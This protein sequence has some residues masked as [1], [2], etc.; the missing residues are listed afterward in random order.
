MTVPY[1]SA[2]TE[3]ADH[4]YI[5]QNYSGNRQELLGMIEQSEERVKAFIDGYRKVDVHTSGHADSGAIKM[6]MEMTTP[7]I[8]IPIHTEVPTAFDRIYNKAKLVLLQD[9]EEFT[10]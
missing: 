1:R 9:G 10:M 2:F 3:I 6:L 8:I 4:V 5:N 7:D